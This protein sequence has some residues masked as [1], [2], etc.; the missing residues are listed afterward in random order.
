MLMLAAKDA[1]RFAV[2]LGRYQ[3]EVQALS[4]VSRESPPGPRGHLIY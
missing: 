4:A 3:G 2:K 1:R